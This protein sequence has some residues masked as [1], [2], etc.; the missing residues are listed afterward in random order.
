MCDSEITLI[1]FEE[2]NTS[3]PEEINEND[4]DQIALASA[5]ALLNSDENDDVDWSEIEFEGPKNYDYNNSF[6][7]INDDIDIKIEK[8]FVQNLVAK[9]SSVFDHPNSAIHYLFEN[10]LEINEKVATRHHSRDVNHY[11]YTQL[12]NMKKQKDSQVSN[13][14]QVSTV[15]QHTSLELQ[16]ESLS[17][18]TDHLKKIRCI[19][20]DAEKAIL[21]QLFEFEKELPEITISKVL[22]E[23]QTV[24]SNWTAKRVK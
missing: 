15:Q 10:V 9:L 19:T 22:S 14:T 8:T 17:S 6:Q 12:E 20:T 18:K 11:T 23:I 16:Q 5:R 2:Y 7:T 21:V 13:H 3:I 24:S 1:D 4:I